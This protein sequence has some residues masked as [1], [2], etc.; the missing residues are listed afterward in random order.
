MFNYGIIGGGAVFE[1]FQAKALLRTPGLNLYAI[2]DID[3]KRLEAVKTKYGFKKA[4]TDYRDLLKDKEVD[5]I[6]VNLPQHLHLKICRD[7]ARAKK[8]IYVE[9]PIASNLPDAL[10]IIE[11]CRKNRV[12]LCVGHQ[13]RFINIERKAKEIIDNGYLGKVFKIRVIACWYEPRENLLSKGWWYK[14]ECG[15]G[16]L[17]RWGVHK[18]DTLR[19]LLGQEA[20]RVYA[21]MDTFVHKGRDITVED[22]LAALIR[23]NKGTIAELEVSNS[24]HEGKALRGETIEIWG[25][26]GTLWYRPSIGEMELYSTT[27]KPLAGTSKDKNSVD[28]FGFL[29]MNLAPDGNE[30]VRIHRLFMKSISKGRATPVTGYDGYKAL[31]M[32]VGCY[33]SALDKKA[34]NLPL[35]KR[36]LY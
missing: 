34:V 24:Q 5:I 28:K 35:P 3:T 36:R 33:K 1:V 4:F 29:K 8:H 16:P 25:D 2:A 7:G 9:K 12:K 30:F 21:E 32:V 23:F 11:V 13:R 10:R 19:Y 18:T 15:G 14:K 20:V 17:M 31:E 26:K 6:M 22:N 27:R